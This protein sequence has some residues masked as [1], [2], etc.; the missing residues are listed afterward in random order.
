[1]EP[2]RKRRHTSVSSTHDQDNNETGKLSKSCDYCRLKKVKCD[3]NKP[4]CAFCLKNG[5][6]ICNY[7]LMKKPGLKPGYG[8]GMTQRLDHLEDEVTFLRNELTNMKNKMDYDSDRALYIGTVESSSSS[9]LGPKSLQIPT[10]LNPQGSS[11]SFGLPSVNQC[12]FLV[13]LFFLKIISIF[14][15][16][17]T[18]NSKDFENSI[19]RM[20]E[21]VEPPL[22]IY[23]I[24][25]IT[26][27]FLN[28]DQMSDSD[29][30]LYYSK[31]K[32]KI[33]STSLKKIN[34]ESLQSM[35]LLAYDSLGGSIK[36]P[37]AWNYVSIASDYANYL[38]LGDE[39]GI[40][41][42]MISP[43][44]PNSINS[45]I[46]SNDTS[47][48]K[49]YKTI[50]SKSLNLLK[51]PKT[52]VDEESRRHCFW[53]IFILD[54]LYAISSSHEMKLKPSKATCLLPLELNYWINPKPNVI[55]NQNKTLK[56]IDLLSK[57]TPI[58]PSN[59][60]SPNLIN[61]EHYDSFS[62]YI[63]LNKLIGD[64]HTFLIEDID[65]NDHFEVNNWKITFKNIENQLYLWLNNSIP[66]KYK[67]FLETSEIDN[68][69]IYDILFFVFYYTTLIKLHGANAY[70][71]GESEFFK[72]S[73]SSRKICIDSAIR[74]Y[75]FVSNLKD[76]Q[77][78]E[79]LG[80]HFGFYIWI[81][82]RILFMD[83]VYQPNNEKNIQFQN[84]LNYFSDILFRIG[85]IWESSMVYHKILKFLNVQ[86]LSYVNN[87]YSSSIHNS[88]SDKLDKSP[89]DNEDEEIASENKEPAI[90]FSDIRN[91]SHSLL[92]W[93][94][95]LAE[96]QKKSNINTK[97]LFNHANSFGNFQTTNMQ[98]FDEFQL[99]HDD[100]FN[101]LALDINGSGSFQDIR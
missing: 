2:T 29:K 65:I 19:Q 8:K 91:A 41:L 7:S 44:S 47:A 9:S 37:E 6:D 58:S 23:S 53:C 38:K 87:L 78:F 25:L 57:S 46:H 51:K 60:L 33:I 16:I 75:N 62:F 42:S 22:I 67:L 82:S 89:D 35:I 52:W 81:S 4:T 70:P 101:F 27:K 59:G 68:L 11:H 43:D 79:S 12:L 85:K 32:E 92:F 30:K 55:I 31:C 84:I 73:S 10:L 18:S 5:M 45:S 86:D 99:T 49:E 54:K 36:V 64:I 39:A 61:T 98:S 83:A 100:F 34:L 3:G 50:T 95:K 56:Q 97:S 76:D 26:L 77:I 93:F 48:R 63:E 21:G 40:K 24:V 17:H 15:L 69:K 1:M 13:D 66:L 90:V 28:N 94:N 88:A 96:K 14:P 72:S 20:N 71:Q 80:P 74:V